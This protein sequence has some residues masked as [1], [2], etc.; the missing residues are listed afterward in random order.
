MS[1]PPRVAGQFYP[2]DPARLRAIV[3]QLLAD[4]PTSDLPRR[5]A[6]VV[7]PHAGYVYS[8]SV[9]GAAFRAA[10]NRIVET[11]V[12]V[13]PSHRDAFDGASVFSGDAYETPLGRIPIDVVARTE[14][15]RLAPRHVQIGEAGHREEH[16]I[17]VQ[18]PFV[19]AVF[20]GAMLLPIT[21]LDRSRELCRELG[22]AIARL[23]AGHP[24]LL[25]ASS[26]LYHGPSRHRCEASDAR[27][28]DA[29]RR[30]APDDFLAG[31]AD[32]S[33]QA[34][35]A[36]P[37]AVA[38]H[39]A[40]AEGEATAEVLMH[41]TSADVTDDDSY[42]VGYAAVSLGRRAADE[43]SR[44]SDADRLLHAARQAIADALAGGEV[45]SAPPRR[46]ASAGGLFVTLR[47]GSSLRGCIG[48]TER[49]EDLA[50]A[51]RDIAC[52]AAFGDPRFDPVRS[53]E[54]SDLTIE[55]S[56][57]SPLEV[58]PDPSPEKI[59]V[60]LH[61]LQVEL[62]DNRGILLPQVAVEA[63]WDARQF[64]SETCRKAGLPPDAWKKKGAIVRTFTARKLREAEK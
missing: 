35:G 63:G 33:C 64:L 3:D 19:Q 4:A 32:G 8:G 2:S 39:A 34:C 1:R 18:L 53:D 6:A 49:H 46:G 28:L 54:L 26:D 41:R 61:G 47:A 42:V 16:A 22:V 40:Q 31:V 11:V 59:R 56:L 13:A 48:L 14:L 36:G 43:F 9:A 20:P 52:S 30:A 15:Q 10:A 58:L 25:V 51:V 7:A 23:A 50:T 17:E 60:G 44:A 38:L 27:T 57:L 29:V 5:P 21:M 24:M 55:I 45:G 12:V 62:G 37:I